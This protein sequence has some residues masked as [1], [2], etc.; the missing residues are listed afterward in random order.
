MDKRW[1]NLG[2]LVLVVILFV[3][4]LFVLNQPV[5]QP[6]RSEL[7]KSLIELV[8]LTE[9]KNIDFN[10]L[11]FGSL[12][13]INSDQ[14]ILFDQAKLIDLNNSLDSFVLSQKSNLS[15]TDFSKLSDFILLINKKI[16][17]YNSYFS[18]LQKLDEID[19]A[20]FCDDLDKVY[21]DI[22]PGILSVNEEYS[23]FD[24]S[25]IEYVE[26][27]NLSDFSLNSGFEKHYLSLENI[28][29][30]LGTAIDLC[31]VEN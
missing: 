27:Y 23:E 24:I 6:S 3:V 10:N 22:F 17:L 2:I 18:I 12:L 19:L 26:K 31:E 25:N 13:E 16:S 14:E 9:S 15:E 20:W 5:E 30:N 29:D 11:I 21:F 8:E 7:E 1:R 28:V 4:I